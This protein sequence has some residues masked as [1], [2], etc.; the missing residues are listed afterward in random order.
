M[1]VTS[2]GG[3]SALSAAM[4]LSIAWMSIG[5]ANE[6][7]SAH[8]NEQPRAARK[9]YQAQC[10]ALYDHLLEI[11][12]ELIRLASIRTALTRSREALGRAVR[13]AQ[14]HDALWRV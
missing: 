9:R 4:R 8:A 13:H 12:F 6:T 14:I 3:S 1:T 5:S 11:L 10:R 7:T 2:A